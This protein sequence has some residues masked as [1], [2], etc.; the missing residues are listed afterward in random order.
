MAQSNRT[1]RYLA[2]A[3]RR[4]LYV[5]AAGT[6]LRASELASLTPTSFE[7]N[8]VPP[9]V[10]M[11]AAY[12]KYKKEAELPLTVEVV[13]LLRAH[14]GGL[15]VDAPVWPGTWSNAASAKMIR[16]DLKEARKKWLQSFQDARQQAEAEQS[17]F[18]AYR[19]AAGFVA[20][21]HSL[22]HLFVFARGPIRSDAES[23]SRTGP[24]L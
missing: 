15:P 6:G 16:L 17:D 24:A 22:R 13:D 2:G 3:D 10:R 7:L 14:L 4:A 9:V 23:C 11:Q 20:D 19:D 12:T 8:T 1:F 21:F 5:T 18:L